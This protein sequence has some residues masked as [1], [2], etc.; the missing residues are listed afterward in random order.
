M[1]AILI[2]V[3]LSA[4]AP[5]SEPIKVVHDMENANWFY[6]N[7]QPGVTTEEDMKFH[8]APAQ[9]WL[10]E[11]ESPKEWHH[12]AGYQLQSETNSSFG[13]IRT[14]LIVIPNYDYTRYVGSS[15]RIL[16]SATFNDGVL[17][18]MTRLDLD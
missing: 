11:N 5:F 13:I 12:R 16:Y 3:G 9:L 2:L 10:E 7:A 1:L 18:T 6:E 4:C 15:D 17:S 14:Y 8:M